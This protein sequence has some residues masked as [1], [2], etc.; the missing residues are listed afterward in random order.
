MSGTSLYDRLGGVYSIAAVIDHFSDA[1]INNKLVG[2]TSKNTALA[3]WHSNQTG[4]RLA[5]LKFMRTLWVCALAGGPQKFTPSQPEFAQG[6]P[7]NLEAQHKKFHIS[8][9][10]FTEVAAEL[11]RSLDHFNV[12]AREKAEVLA[13]FGAHMSEV[14]HGS[15]P[16]EAYA[17][18][19]CPAQLG[20]NLWLPVS[21]WLPPGILPIML[22]AIVIVLLLLLVFNMPKLNLA[23]HSTQQVQ[24][25]QWPKRRL[26]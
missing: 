11:T 3:E 2:K 6:C 8:P 17:P 9:A 21:R 19:P 14:T 13:A 23:V 4:T 1:L 20:R 12:P 18:A 7:F 22:I 15:R 25:P 24:Q 5:G 10:E 16:T 26:W